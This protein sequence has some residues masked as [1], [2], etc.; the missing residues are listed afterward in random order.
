MNTGFR[1]CIAWQRLLLFAALC[2]GTAAALAQPAPPASAAGPSQEQRFHHR[3]HPPH[4]AFMRA[5]HSLDL[6]EGQRQQIR[7]LM[8]AQWQQFK[9]QM[10]ALRQARRA[11]DHALPGSGE[12]ASAQAQLQQAALNAVQARLQF[13]VNLRNQ[14]YALLTDPQKAQLSQALSGGR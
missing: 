7:D 9:P 8:R 12:F 4:S 1:R 6:S 10:Q 13:E 2:G 3:W 11:F 14:I 5:V